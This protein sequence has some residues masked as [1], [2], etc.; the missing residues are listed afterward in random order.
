MSVFQLQ[1]CRWGMDR[2]LDQGLKS[3]DGAMSV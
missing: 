2:G 3:W 1:L